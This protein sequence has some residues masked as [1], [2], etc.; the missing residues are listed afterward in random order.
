MTRHAAPGPRIA[1]DVELNMMGDWGI[2]NLHRICGWLAAELWMRTGRGSRFATWNGTGG[3]MAIDAVLDGRMH[4]ALFVPAPFSG[5]AFRGQGVCNRPDMSRL[6]ALGT[7][8]QDDRLVI[9]VAADR[10][11]ANLEAFR[12]SRPK[13]A[14]A[15][16]WDDGDNMVGLA[17]THLLEAA[18]M[19]RAAIEAWGGSFIEGEAPWD[20]MPH[21]IDGRA[22]AVIFE[23]IMTPYWKRL[24]AKRRMTFLPIDDPV[25][26]ALKTRFGWPRGTVPIDRFAGLAA[27]FETLDFSDFALLCRD[28]L[29]DDLAYCIA[30][31]LCE[32]RATIEQQYRHL[33]RADSPL[34][35]PLDPAKIART[36]VPLHPGAQRYYT[37]RGLH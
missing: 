34:T 36:A 32:T 23:A 8:P 20:I 31:C 33:A 2:A 22:D 29:P 19:P 9:A 6:R 10:G 3:R 4:A 14:I 24:L 21:V 28:D 18:G 27:P 12:R 16:A 30:W 26:S 35:Y 15:T 11:I 37:E 5:T 17:V 25:L 7:L 13:L 1:R